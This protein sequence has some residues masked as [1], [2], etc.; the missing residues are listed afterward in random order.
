MVW[1]RR[2]KSA[3]LRH[4]RREGKWPKHNFSAIW[5]GRIILF[6]AI[7]SNNK[8]LLTRFSAYQIP[9]KLVLQMKDDCLALQEICN[10]ETEKRPLHDK[11]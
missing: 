11:P 9:I 3:L 7:A 6:P 1:Y 5:P 4:Y 8:G 10:A 2:W